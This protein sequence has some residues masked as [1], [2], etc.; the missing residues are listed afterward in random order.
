MHMYVHPFYCRGKKPKQIQTRAFCHGRKSYLIGSGTLRSLLN[1]RILSEYV[2]ACPSLCHQ[3]SSV[4]D[5]TDSA[6]LCILLE[7]YCSK[8]TGVPHEVSQLF[9]GVAL[10]ETAVMCRGGF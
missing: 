10:Y 2:Q 3:W 6:I 8:V 9:V 1:S 5:T 7:E 4:F